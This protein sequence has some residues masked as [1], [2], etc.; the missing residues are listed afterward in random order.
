MAKRHHD[1]DA[2]DTVSRGTDNDD[3]AMMGDPDPDENTVRMGAPAQRMEAAPTDSVGATNVTE[4][5]DY[6]VRSQPLRIDPSNSWHTVTQI[7]TDALHDIRTTLRDASEDLLAVVEAPNLLRATWNPI[8]NAFDSLAA[9]ARPGMPTPP[10]AAAATPLAT[11]V[12]AARDVIMQD[13]DDDSSRISGLTPLSSR[14]GTPV[15]N[16]RARSPQPP[17]PDT[18]CNKG[19]GKAL[20]PREPTPTPPRMPSLVAHPMRKPTLEEILSISDVYT[21]PSS[22]STLYA[23]VASHAAMPTTASRDSRSSS[24]GSSRAA[25]RISSRVEA[26]VKC[27]TVKCRR[28]RGPPGAARCLYIR[29]ANPPTAEAR[30]SPLAIVATTNA[31]LAEHVDD[32]LRLT[33]TSADWTRNG[34]LYI[35]FLEI[36]LEGAEAAI[37]MIAHTRKWGGPTNSSEMVMVERYVRTFQICFRVVACVDDNGQLLNAQQVAEAAFANSS[38]MQAVMPARRINFMPP[39]NG[40]STTTLVIEIVDTSTLARQRALVGTQVAFANGVRT[41]QPLEDR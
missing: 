14:P 11:P 31:A 26:E 16:A 8:A 20:G 29:F 28:V 24:P 25:S 35:Q 13:P 17:T 34:M 39:W 32:R 9:A 12:E 10:A 21:G 18:T 1:P 38:A 6:E 33:A 23:A 40:A 27:K 41:A 19:K 36:P 2:E 22:S 37:R 7:I 15:P 4:V 5:S 30:A 3:D